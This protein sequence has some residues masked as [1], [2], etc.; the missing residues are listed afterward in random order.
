[1]FITHLLDNRS[2]GGGSDLDLPP[3]RRAVTGG[4]AT[5]ALRRILVATD[6]TPASRGALVVAGLLAQ[7]HGAAVDV[8]SVLERWGGPE[9][10]SSG[11][12]DLVA[13]LTTQRLAAI[14]PQ[15]EAAIGRRGWTIKVTDGAVVSSVSAA[16]AHGYDLLVVG[17]RRH[18]MGRGLRRPTALAL[19]HRAGVPVLAVP[20]SVGA[21]PTRAVVGIDG[22]PTARAAA[23]AAIGLMGTPASIDL[24]HVPAA[25]EDDAHDAA[26]PA[27]HRSGGTL[28]ILDELARELE[29]LEHVTVASVITRRGPPAREL[30]AHARSVD[31]DLIAIGSRVPTSLKRELMGGVSR[32][33]LAATD[34]CVLVAGVTDAPSPP[35]ERPRDVVHDASEDSF[36]ASD[37]PGWID[38]RIGKPRR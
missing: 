19:A 9:R 4:A 33:V 37:P 2:T 26:D 8:L 5:R 11:G 3:P 34:G 15:V 1:M 20:S 32:Q 14:V 24:V 23:R 12:A 6:G 17:R 16:A 18:W 30:L 10:T 38:V 28:W 22:S 35:E 36:P 13:E 29:G 7:R 25:A 31:A 27:R 21:L